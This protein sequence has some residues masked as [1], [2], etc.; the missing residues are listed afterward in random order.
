MLILFAVMVGGYYVAWFVC[1][2]IAWGGDEW[3][4][5]VFKVLQVMSP[6]IILAIMAIGSIIFLACAIKKPLQ[7]LDDV[8]DAVKTL[9]N[10]DAPA[11]SLSQELSEV[12]NELNLARAQS[13]E[14]LR[15]RRGAEQRKNDLIMYLAHDLKTLLSSV[16]GYLTLLHDEGEISPELRKKYL[17]IA[18]DK[19]ERLEDLINEFFEIT[20]FNLSEITLQY[21]RINLTRLLEQLVFEFEAM[22]KNKNLRCDLRA[23]N[24]MMLCCDGD[25]IQRV[26]DNLLRNAVLYSYPDTEIAITAEVRGSNAVTCFR[27]HGDTIPEEKLARI[28]EQFYRLDTARSSSGGAGL[29]LAIVRQIV[30]LHGGAIEARSAED[31]IEFTVTLP[32]S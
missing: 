25:K 19:A 28:F 17:S 14:N 32:L 13:R 15:L 26:F 8:I 18:L 21:G 3:L 30:E 29:G 9:S 5:G 23:A 31:M 20:R 2:H 24:D 1:S 11:V 7:Y 4:Y 12:E 10:P 22:L 16:I 6:V 27:N